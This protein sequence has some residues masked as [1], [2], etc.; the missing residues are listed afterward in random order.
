MCTDG[1]AAYLNM[2]WKDHKIIH[3]REI[4][5]NKQGLMKRTMI[6]SNLIEG[7]WGEIKDFS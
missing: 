2:P 7:L 1:W 6:N 3:K 5:Y 4:H